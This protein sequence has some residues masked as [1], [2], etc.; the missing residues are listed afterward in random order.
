LAEASLKVV[1]LFG[2]GP[3]LRVLTPRIRIML[4]WSSK[5][6][7]AVWQS[8]IDDVAA[9]TTEVERTRTANE[10]MGIVTSCRKTAQIYP[11]IQ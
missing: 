8:G 7:A 11:Q 10:G 5:G 1:W 9:M 2:S 3:L 4:A 6:C